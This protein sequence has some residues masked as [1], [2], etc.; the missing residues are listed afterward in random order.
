MNLSKDESSLASV[1]AIPKP[2]ITE[3]PILERKKSSIT[4]KKGALTKKVSGVKPKCPKGW[5]KK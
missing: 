2:K 4:C 5:S 3:K 1:D